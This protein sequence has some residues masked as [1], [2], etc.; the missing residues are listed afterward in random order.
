MKKDKVFVYG[1][2]KAGFPNHHINKG[3]RFRSSFRTTESF[4]L[5]LEGERFTPW[6]VLDAGKGH[7]IKGEVYLA[8]AEEL[9]EMDVLERITEPDGYHRVVTKVECDETGEFIDVYVYGK[10]VEQLDSA[11]IRQQLRD[12]YLPQHGELYSRRS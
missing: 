12:E 4:P 7:R 11:D 1:T 5:Y 2:L 8:N 9:A 6:M 3:L 10:P